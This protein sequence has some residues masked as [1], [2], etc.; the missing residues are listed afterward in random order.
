MET[1]RFF[2]DRGAD[3][4][5]V[6][7]LG[8]PLT[9]AVLSDLTHPVPEDEDFMGKIELFLNRGVNVNALGGKYGSAPPAL[10]SW[11][12]ESGEGS[13]RDEAF[14]WEGD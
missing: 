4:E 11:F 12:T 7:E 3:L 10:C 13:S 1:L 9:L 5:A 2:I 14:D 6:S 8:T